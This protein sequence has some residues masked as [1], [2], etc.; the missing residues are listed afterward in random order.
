M[1]TAYKVLGQSAPSTNTDTNIYTVPSSTQTVVSTISVAN[2]GTSAAKFRIAVRPAGA[3]IA[4][5][6]YVAYDVEIGAESVIALTLGI[7]LNA[8]DVVTVR[9]NSANLS[10]SAFGSEIS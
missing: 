9:A 10:F 3:S 8:T 5:Q 1:A 2:R 7:T 6:H 4:N